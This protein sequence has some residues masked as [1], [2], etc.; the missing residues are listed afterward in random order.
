MENFILIFSCFALGIFFRRFK[1]FPA[2][3]PQVLNKF[4]IYISLPALTISQI[5]KLNLA[6]DLWVPVSMSWIVYFL[7]LGFFW[8]ISRKT[9]MS[10]KSLG[11]L[12]LTGSLGNTSFVGFPLLEALYGVSA[13]SVG[14]LVDQPGTFLVAGS[15]GVATAAYFAGG[16]VS[17][18][19]IAKKV[20]SFPPLLALLCAFPLRTLHFSEEAFHILDRLGSTLIPLSLISVGMQLHFQKDKIKTHFANLC[21]GLGF[22]LFLAPLVCAALYLGVFQLR[23]ET[24]VITLVESAM[25]PMITAG[26]LAVEYELDSELAHLMI[27]IGI[28]LSLVTVPA[29]AWLLRTF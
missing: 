29:W 11:T 18:K 4:V 27:G 1:V 13:L 19:E 20:F 24:V 26:I 17:F 10:Q 21:W 7:G 2:N 25:A 6:G 15:L 16:A 22:K 23:G 3:T 12:I 5:H 8:M 9:S 28:P 14:I